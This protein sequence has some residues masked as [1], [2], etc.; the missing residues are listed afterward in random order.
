M[1][2]MYILYGSTIHTLQNCSKYEESAFRH[3]CNSVLDLN[4]II[5]SSAC[6]SESI[7][8]PFER[9]NGSDIVF[10]NHGKLLIYSL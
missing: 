9:T 2:L 3:F 8:V 1:L 5:K 4:R 7:L 10:S 6:R